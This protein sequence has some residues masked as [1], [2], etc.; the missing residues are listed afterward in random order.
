M[1]NR[2]S[3]D[4]V[5]LENRRSELARRLIFHRA[6]TQTIGRLT[7]LSRNRLAA[8]RRRLMVGDE[9][10]LRGPSPSSDDVFLHS[11]QART[12]AAALAA[13]FAL[14]AEHAL[15]S[16]TAGVGPV[17]SFD[18]GEELC[19]IYETYLAYHPNTVVRLEEMMLLKRSLAKG[20]IS[21]GR[22]CRCEGLILIDR[23]GHSG[24]TCWHCRLTNETRSDEGELISR[25]Q[26]PTPSVIT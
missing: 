5:I 8:L 4:S 23:L 1:S 20:D 25:V 12:E 3:E 18:R 14:Y 22:C 26:T 10:R 11:D 2:P 24:L 13:L 9:D 21:V 6:R 7:G 17:S 19:E 16:E 15:T